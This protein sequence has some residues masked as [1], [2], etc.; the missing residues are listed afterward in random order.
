[1]IVLKNDWL[2]ATVINNMPINNVV[3]VVNVLYCIVK[4]Y[5]KIC[6]LM[7]YCG[8]G[9]PLPRTDLSFGYPC[10]GLIVSI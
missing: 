7:N 2:N 3:S 9:Y 1:M 6:G 4:L 5:P 10:E 8:I